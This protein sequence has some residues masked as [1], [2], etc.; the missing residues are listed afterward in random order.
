MKKLFSKT[1]RFALVVVALALQ[2]FLL[3]AAAAHHYNLIIA[4]ATLTDNSV[5]LL[6]D[7]Q[8]GNSTTVYEILVNGK[9]NGSTSKTNY[10][11]SNL[12]P[13][14]LYSVTIRI[15]QDKALASNTIKFKTASKGKIYNILDYGAKSDSANANTRAIQAAINACTKGGTVYIPKGTFVSGALFLKSDMTLFIETGGTLKGSVAV[16]DY[17]PM[18]PNRFEGWEMK[19]YASLLNAGTLNRNGTYN[20][21]NLRITG[22]GT[23]SGGG[24]PL[25]EAMIKASG[26]RSRGRLICLM[27]CQNVS[28][29][30]LTIT[31]PP[32]WTIHYIYSDN[33]TCEGLNI[34]TFKIR[35]G[36]GIDP[37]SSTDSYIFNCTFDTGDDC[38]AIK[39]GKN[40]EGFWVGKP[41][42][43]VRITDC[44][45]KRGHGISIGSEMSGGVS[46]VLVQDCKA[47]ALL[48]GMQIKGTKERGGYVKNVTVADCQLLQITVFSA[49]NYN[50]DGEAAPEP[51]TFENFVFK[52]IDLSAASAKEPAININGFKDPAHRLKNVTFLN[53][54]MPERAK[55]IVND[56]EQV[57]FTNVKSAMGAKPEYT[58]TSSTGVSY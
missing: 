44:D 13:A 20:V 50:N 32:S 31:E 24:R 30:G 22:G 26:M 38:I 14:S 47:G 45:F 2:S 12:L 49:V 11:V 43:N 51:P 23:I 25:G 33:I 34:V 10:T 1:V 56:A 35:N 41:T 7:K 18:I 40:P 28:L 57:R 21:K 58:V 52:N 16:E 42:K 17:L 5:S 8:Y 19:T 27:N 39:S 6:W 15:K 36:D 29:S 55:V 48:H 54:K 53:I 46:D 37:D 9:I 3:Q 4:P